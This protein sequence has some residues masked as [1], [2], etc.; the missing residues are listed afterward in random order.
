MA[1]PAANPAITTSIV[2]TSGPGTAPL[3]AI[4]V[5]AAAG[6]ATPVINPARP[7]PSAA[8]AEYQST[9]AAAVTISAR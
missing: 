4:P 2:E 5:S 7:E 3:T 8:T 1:S 9:N 6:G